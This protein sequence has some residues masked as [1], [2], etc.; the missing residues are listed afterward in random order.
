MK[1]QD[2]LDADRRGDLPLA[3][4]L[5]EELLAKGEASLEVL[6]NLAILYWVAT[7][8]GM[9]AAIRWGAD[10]WQT[11]ARRFPELLSEA[12]SRFPTSVEPRF[13]RR[14]IAWA[15]LGEPFDED[16]CRALLR[17]DPAN[18]LPA[19]YLFATSHG[20]EAQTE[21]LELLR[22]CREDGTTRAGYV[23]SVLE[24]ALR[25]AGRR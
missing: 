20:K 11:A 14:Y 18:P 23:V 25:Q 19:L 5:Y 21:A 6:L 1:L 4:A 12:E 22:R 24:S 7:D 2:A 8:P 3:A 16:E 15:D 9:A 17:E 13:W 10:F